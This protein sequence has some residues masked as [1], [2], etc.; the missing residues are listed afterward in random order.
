MNILYNN[1]TKA[2]DGDP[3]YSG[4]GR[5]ETLQTSVDL[6]VDGLSHLIAIL[7]IEGVIRIDDLRQNLIN[8]HRIRYG[9]GGQND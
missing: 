5:L 9:R 4:K 2:F 6:L 7:E 1:I 3:T 8:G